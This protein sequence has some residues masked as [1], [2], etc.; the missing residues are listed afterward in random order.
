MTAVYHPLASSDFDQ[1]WGNT[2]AINTNDD[3][4][5]IPSIV[6]FRTGDVT[7]ATGV[8][9]RT[10]LTDTGFTAGVLANQFP[11]ST[12]GGVLEVDRVSSGTV[13]PTIALQG[14][15]GTDYEGIVVYLNTTGR[16]YP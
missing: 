2:G 6:G 12:T 13:N 9:P 4:S 7:S 10:I 14:S 5:N 16:K 3:W 15:N 8:D 11:T 1:N